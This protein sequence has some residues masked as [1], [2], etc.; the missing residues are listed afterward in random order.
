MHGL[1]AT[2]GNPALAQHF[3]MGSVRDRLAA[4]HG[5]EHRATPPSQA[6]NTMPGHDSNFARRYSQPQF[7]FTA[8]GQP[9]PTTAPSHYMD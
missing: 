5:S 1:Q 7:Q 9:L 4:T 8:M 2:M 6:F 3:S